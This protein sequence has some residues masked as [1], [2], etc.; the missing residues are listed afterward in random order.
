[1]LRSCCSGDVVLDLGSKFFDTLERSAPNRFL[2][3]NVEPDFDLVQAGGVGW[4]KQESC[5]PYF[6]SSTIGSF[7]SFQSIIPPATLNALNPR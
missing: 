3:D 1:M 4:S 2:R 6:L 7:S 5:H